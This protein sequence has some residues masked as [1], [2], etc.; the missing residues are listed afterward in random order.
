MATFPA[1]KPDWANLEV[2]H[3]N[4]L[5][6]RADF[7]NY[8]S[9]AEAL[10]RDTTK[11]KTH[12]LSGTWKFNLANS[13]FEAPQD[14]ES[15]NFDSSQ[16]HHVAVPGMW[17]LQGHGKG[18]HYTNVNFP[19][20]VDP[21]N[22]PF[23]DNECGSYL[24]TFEVPANLKD[25]QL[26]LR[27]E[28]VDSAYHVWINGE[29]VGYSTVSRNASEFDVTNYVK[30]DG[31]NSLAVR[32]YQFC[33][34]SYIED[35]DQWRMSGIF[36]DV[37]LM[38]F[39]S[40]A[41]IEDV[42]LQT[43]LD[44]EYHNATLK[45]QVD[46]A[47]SGQLGLRL[48]DA[49]DK[50]VAK[51]QKAS[52]SAGGL[53]KL[54]FD[55]PVDNPNK[56]TAETPYLY[57]LVL[58]LDGSF[59]SQRVGFRQVELKDGLIKVN[60]KRV[61]FKGANRH[62]HHPQFGRAVP[63]EFMKQDLVLMKT[64]NLNSIRTCHQPSDIRLYDLADEL[65]F[66]VMDEADLE[67]H[68]FE[69]IA[70][71]AL[72][73][74]DRA[75]S[76]F[77]RQQLTKKSAAEWTS[78]N[79]DW[80]EAYVDRARQ[81]VYRDKLHPSVIMWSL[82]N[83]SF[84]G[85]NHIAMVDWIRDSDNTRLIH[86][87]PDLD[88][89]VMDM[90]SRMY[91]YMKVLTDFAADKSKTKPL[92]LCEYIH[93]MG[94]GPGNIKEYL[95]LFYKHDCLQGGWVWEW[96]NHGLLTKTKDGQEYYAY[97]GD[98]G[99]EPND[100]NFVMD[101]VLDSDHKPNSG[102]IE[103]KKASEPV[104]MLDSTSQSVTIINR[105]DFATLD[106][107]KCLWSVVSEDGKTGESGILD[108]PA[109]VQPGATTEIALP[110]VKQ[111]PCAETLVELSFQLKADTNWAKAGFEVAFLQAPIKP[112]GPLSLP[113]SSSSDAIKVEQ[114]DS[115]L[116][117]SGGNSE[118][119]VDLVRGT[120]ASWKKSGKEIVTQPLEPTFYRAPTDN[121]APQDGK[122]WKDRCLD[123]ASLHTRSAQ[124]RQL[125]TSVTVELHQK[126][127]PKVLSWSLDLT[128]TYTFQPTGDVSLHIKGHPSG[129]NLPQTL[130]RV[131]VT[132]GLAKTFDQVEWFGR[133]PGESY[134]DM[135]L[136]QRVGLWKVSRV[137]ALWAAP[138]FPQ[139]CSNRTDTRFVR[140]S[141][142]ATSLVAQFFDPRAAA[143]AV[144]SGGERRRTLFDFMASHYHV[145]DVE[146][147]RH[148]FELEA[149]KRED[150][151]LRL[152]ARHH[153]LGTGSCGPATLEQYRLETGDFEFAMVLQ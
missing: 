34:S 36:R 91:P 126:Y 37:F 28:G 102:L 63:Y 115:Q 10:S 54:S 92:V 55:I 21:P 82:G 122:D 118:W 30:R 147:A 27:F 100:G 22:P 52:S 47:G 141:D 80:R 93:A 89:E 20:F 153:G 81:M 5:K 121:D 130:A 39:P 46:V 67:C 72:D 111:R 25:H 109:G 2:L 8:A 66:W 125:D 84:Y 23:S 149:C 136:S 59:I 98:F 16:W 139:E 32:V 135:K 17:Q 33:S 83:E 50:E 74:K 150:V 61:L 24:T 14:F 49:E 87:E 73:P 1:H 134:T 110:D 64:H 124:W 35:Q 11:A 148:P 105:Q 7:H 19:F 9:E 142:G 41:R 42:T 112:I 75:L 123:T 107:F 62:E 31:S 144:G 99:D 3:R 85:K 97:G 145:R 86:Y 143:A 45:V 29:E 70:D 69:T 18:P 12:C 131:G 114:S 6:P 15:S 108:I 65:G 26:R 116:K 90:H 132:L 117:V 101:G 43:I 103:Y 77:E 129:T 113:A 120:L 76:F 78:N 4:T 68:G 51:A 104:Q 13:P 119:A 58:S 127:A 60:G 38:G 56:W 133:G 138:E 151:L 57:K 44:K 53:E 79:P 88:A 128:T 96:A 140:L 94:T 152:D 71:A 137:D 106:A 95:D 48:L 146:R 40:K